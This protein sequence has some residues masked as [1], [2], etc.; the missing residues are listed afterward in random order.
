MLLEK[1]GRR[2]NQ[3]AGPVLPEPW[4]RT[5]YIPIDKVDVDKSSL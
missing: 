4:N 3:T 2:A 5:R 1:F